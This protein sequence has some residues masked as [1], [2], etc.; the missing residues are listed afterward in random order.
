[1]DLDV[2]E[3]LHSM[4]VIRGGQSYNKDLNLAWNIISGSATYAM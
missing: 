4:P 2:V 3:Q 1:M